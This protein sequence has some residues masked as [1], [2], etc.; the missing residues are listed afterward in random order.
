MSINFPLFLLSIFS[1]ILLW[2]EKIVG[3]ISI[4]LKLLTLVLLPNVIYPEESS[5]FTWKKC[6]LM[7]LG[8]IF[9]ICPLG[10]F[11]LYYYLSS[12]FLYWFSVWGSIHYWKLGIEIPHHY[13]IAIYFYSNRSKF[14]SINVFQFFECSVILTFAFIYLC[15]L[16]LGI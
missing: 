7:L 8:G 16:M 2:L 9:C 14:S 13:C 3:M 12:L 11:F 6:I 10:P 4:F 5:F 1:F 15:S